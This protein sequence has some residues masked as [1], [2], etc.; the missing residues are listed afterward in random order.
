MGAGYGSDQTHESDM[1]LPRLPAETSPFLWGA[2]CGALA[3]AIVGFSWGGWVTG[4]TALKQAEAKADEAILASLVPICVAQF[5]SSPQ[6]P[7]R[8][9]ALRQAS[10]WEQGEFVS[11]GGWATMP[12]ATGEPNRNVAAACAEILSRPAS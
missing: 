9:A 10:S 7:G 1:N 6:A 5:R 11:K 4:S 2:A 8:L 12:G 3:L